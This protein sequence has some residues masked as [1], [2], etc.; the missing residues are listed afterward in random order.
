MHDRI[1]ARLWAD[2][3]A[4]FSADVAKAYGWVIQT[5]CRISEIQFRSPWRQAGNE[6]C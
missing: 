2:H 5:F 4:Q 6:T 3:G 1:D